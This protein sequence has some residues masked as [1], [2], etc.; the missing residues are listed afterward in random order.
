M[1]LD[2]LYHQQTEGNEHKRESCLVE[3]FPALERAVGSGSVDCV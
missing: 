3:F 1:R 2:G